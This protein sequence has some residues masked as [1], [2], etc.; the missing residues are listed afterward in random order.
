MTRQALHGS[1]PYGR[2]PQWKTRFGSWINQVTVQ[3]IANKLS[4]NPEL[5]VTPAAIYN[6]VHRRNL[7][8]AHVIDA[9]VDL[10]DGKLTMKDIFEHYSPPAGELAKGEGD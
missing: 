10:S 8:R 1:R 3:T 7:P 5:A 6:W 9:L 2:G 4:A